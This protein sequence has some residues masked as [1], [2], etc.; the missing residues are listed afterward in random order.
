MEK[1]I[2]SFCVIG[3]LF[4]QSSYPGYKPVQ[5]VDDF[6]K[7]FTVAAA[8]VK[9]IKADFT[10]KKTLVALTETIT[11]KGTLWFKQTDKVRMDYTTPFVYKM[12]INGDNMLVKDAQKETR[13]S[14]RSNKL[15]QQVNRIMIDC[16]QGS[17]LESKD[18]SNRVF[19][20]DSYYL[21]ELTPTSKNLQQ[22]FSTIIVTV[23]KKD[24]SPHIIELNE[25]GGDKTIISLS[26]KKVNMALP[27]EVFSF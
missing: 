20:N 22:F 19:E 9:D 24:N 7:K 18:F 15:L 1:V 2:V 17:L 4:L 14:A 27:D 11:S 13:M 23:E 3:L 5:D 6:R 26:N 25:S 21:L 12:I 16:M 10:Q 8:A